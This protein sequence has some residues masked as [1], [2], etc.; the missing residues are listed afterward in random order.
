[1]LQQEYD[2]LIRATVCSSYYYLFKFYN[3]VALFK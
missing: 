1:M 2:S 3:E